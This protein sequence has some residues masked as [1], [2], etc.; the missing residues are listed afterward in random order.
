MASLPIVSAEIVKSYKNLLDEKDYTQYNGDSEPMRAQ[1]KQHASRDL[2]SLWMI[3]SIKP[4][5]SSIFC[6]F[7]TKN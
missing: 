4:I 2:Y 5:V 7:G 1:F 3:K 6:L